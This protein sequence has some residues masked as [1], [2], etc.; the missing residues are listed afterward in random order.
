MKGIIDRF[1]GNFAVIELENR[2][3]IDL[4]RHLLPLEAHEGDVVYEEEGVYRID[5]EE[6]KKAKEDISKLMD[7]LWDSK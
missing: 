2:E 3:T 1:E 6:T 4:P 5:H 7:N